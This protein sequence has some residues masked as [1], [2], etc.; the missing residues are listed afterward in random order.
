MMD[1]PKSETDARN[2]AGDYL[3]KVVEHCCDVMDERRVDLDKFPAAADGAEKWDTLS[4]LTKSKAVVDAVKGLHVST[5]DLTW[6]GGDMLM[7][8]VL[9]ETLPRQRLHRWLHRAFQVVEG[10]LPGGRLDRMLN[11]VT[12]AAHHPG[13]GSFESHRENQ[14]RLAREARNTFQRLEL[15]LLN[16]ARPVSFTTIQHTLNWLGVYT[17]KDKAF[18]Y[19]PLDLKMVSL[20]K[21]RPSDLDTH[22]ATRKS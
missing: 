9:Q 10:F 3:Q 14:H 7:T 5:N 21:I 12:S 15:D 20:V 13:P 18:P 17:F 22:F 4:Y 2:D 6:R 1:F 16:H 11:E 19:W 8:L